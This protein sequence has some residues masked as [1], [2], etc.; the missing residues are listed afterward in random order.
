M[1]TIIVTLAIALTLTSCGQHSIDEG[2]N[3]SSSSEE[4]SVSSSSTVVFSGSCDIKDYRTVPIGSQVWMAEN[5]NCDVEGSKCYDNKPEN[6][7]KYGR[8]YDWETAKTVCPSGWHLPS[9]EEWGK[10][11]R[12][13]DGTSGTI[14]TYYSSPTAGRYLKAKSGWVDYKG[15]PTGN[16]EDTYGFSALPG[17]H[18]SGRP[19]RDFYDAGNMGFWWSSS[20][21]DGNY[22]HFR[23]M[24]YSREYAYWGREDGTYCLYSVRC[25]SGVSS[26]S[27]QHSSSSANYTDKGNDISSYK[28]V[29]ISDQTW[30]AENLNYKVAGSLCYGEGNSGYSASEVQFNCDKYGRLYDWATAMELPDKCNRT[31]EKTDPVNCAIQ[32]KHRGI[33]PSGWHL[34]SNAEWDK[35]IRYLDGDKDT[36]SPYTSLTAAIHLRAASGWYDCGP[37]GSGS[38]YSCEDPYGFSALPGGKGYSDGKF[39][40]VGYRSYWW[41]SSEQSF[42]AYNRYI[43]HG[44]SGIV[45]Y[46]SDRKGENL[47]SIRC[48]ED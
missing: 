36:Y 11:M 18:C 47:V 19:C 30:M 37:S 33:C 13:V 9:D 1:K 39:N 23:D 27:A 17:G 42:L 26:P 44:F 22:A 43:Q 15:E 21:Y 28:T 35:L 8:L 41:S 6:C 25:V 4:T 12:Y 31:S 46:I 16:G 32:N 34:P 40:F 5:L 24:S 14:N 38:R 20:E 45:S 2:L 7:G 29:T 48:V 3:D 10:L